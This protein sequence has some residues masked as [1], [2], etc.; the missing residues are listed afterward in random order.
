MGP[1]QVCTVSPDR[2]HFASWYWL[3]GWRK[4]QG[5]P[6]GEELRREGGR[7]SV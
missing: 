6:I 3:Q 1:L 2:C 7:D 5:V 4:Y